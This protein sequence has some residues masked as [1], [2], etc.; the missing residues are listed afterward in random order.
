MPLTVEECARR[1]AEVRDAMTAACARAGRDPA[2]VA[3]VAVSKL[4]PAEAVRAMAQAGQTAFGESYVQEALDKQ[5]RLADLP[6]AWHFI[7]GLQSNKARQVVGRFTLVHSVGSAKLARVLHQKSKEAGVVQDILLQVNLGRELQK[8]GILEE[9]LPAL[10]EETAGL[11]HIRVVGLMTLPPFDDDPETARPYFAR[12]RELRD[13]LEGRLGRKLPH[14][15]MG[16][17]GD[18]VQAVE[19][20]AS[21]VRIGTKLFGPRPG[22]AE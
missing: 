18:F 14:L 11:D 10:A 12:L 20:G 21:L 15:S 1:L 9:D 13:G 4:H 22:P 5:A 7:G 16:M 6:L 17:T 3:L 2:G 19:E 8:S